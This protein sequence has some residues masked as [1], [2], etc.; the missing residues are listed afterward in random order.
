MLEADWMP[1]PANVVRRWHGVLMHQSMQRVQA[2][3]FA[4]YLKLV[5]LNRPPLGS[6]GECAWSV[7]TAQVEQ[8]QTLQMEWRL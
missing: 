4:C 1:I 8:A 5:G 7:A 6:D 3:P 2:L